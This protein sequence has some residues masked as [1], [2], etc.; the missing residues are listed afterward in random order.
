MLQI[1]ALVHRDRGALP[2]RRVE[3]YEECTNVLLEH[4][5]R[6]K[7]L[8]TKLSAREARQILQPVALWMHA[9]E[10]RTRAFEHELLPI[11]AEH[12]ARLPRPLDAVEFLHSVRDR[13]GL[14]TGHGVDE[15]GFQHLSFQEYLAAEEIR[16]TRRIK[17]LV[18]H[19]D[20][21]WWREVT[22]LFVGLGNPS[23]FNELMQAVGEAGHLAGH[24]SFTNECV[25]DALL[26]SA[27]PFLALAGVRPPWW[28]RFGIIRPGARTPSAQRYYA[29]LAMRSLPPAEL[30]K[31]ADRLVRIQGDQN[32]DI[33]RLA[34]SLLVLS[35]GRERHRRARLTQSPG[36]QRCSSILPTA[37]SS[38]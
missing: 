29:L 6:A 21:S 36:S 38:C 16:N 1:I 26:P 8:Q 7:G 31:V 12:C 33:S 13:S 37:A 9:V 28:H 30:A 15:Y 11:V 23:Y 22:R 25:R 34:A 35:G 27:E 32:E 19:Y 24:E 3:L 4:W 2:K 17:V 10:H 5:D 18:E 14:L 20:E